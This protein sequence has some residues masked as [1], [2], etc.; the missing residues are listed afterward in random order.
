MRITIDT[1]EDSSEEIKKVISL[2]SHL[3]KEE[4]K[5]NV[6]A[7]SSEEGDT[8]FA[9]MFGST[10]PVQEPKKETEGTPPDFSGFMDLVENSDKEEKKDAPKIISY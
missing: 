7:P 9:N 5:M 10:E 6:T 1:K 8:A 4:V 3:I 2:L